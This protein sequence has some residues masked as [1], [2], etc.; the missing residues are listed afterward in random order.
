MADVEVGWYDELVREVLGRLLQLRECIGRGHDDGALVASVGMRDL[1]D[2][3]WPFEVG[4]HRI[5]DQLN[6]VDASSKDA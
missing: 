5:D 4:N 2:R 6:A 3:P 1:L